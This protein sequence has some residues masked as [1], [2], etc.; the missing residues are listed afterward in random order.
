M[1]I[2]QGEGTGSVVETH[3]TRSALGPTITRAAWSPKPRSHTRIVPAFRSRAGS[4]HWSAQASDT[5]PASYGWTTSHTLNG[6]TSCVSAASFPA[7]PD[8]FVG[9]YAMH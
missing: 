9:S 6:A 2:T 8:M 7:E 3:A 4:R 5:L 1:H